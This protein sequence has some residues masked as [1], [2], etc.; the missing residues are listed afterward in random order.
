MRVL[1]LLDTPHVAGTEKHVLTLA[2][3]SVKLCGTQTGIVCLKGSPLE[4]A[5]LALGIET[6]PL[7][8]GKNI[9]SQVASLTAQGVRNADILH[10]HNGRTLL[11]A[12][13]VSRNCRPRVVYTQHFLDPGFQKHWGPIRAVYRWGHQAVNSRVAHFIAVSEEAKRRMV[14]REGVSADRITVIPNGIAPDLSRVRS[15]VDVRRELGIGE[16][17]PMAVCVSRLEQ[18]KDVGTLVRAMV[19]VR[20]ELP[21]AMCVIVGDGSQRAALESLAHQ[22]GLSEAVLFAGHLG[23]ALSV[24][25]AGDLLVLSSI[26]EP[27]GLVLLEAMALSKAVVATDAGGPREI[28]LNG[29]TGLLAP[30]RDPVALAGAMTRLLSDRTEAQA[31]GERGRCRFLERYTADRMAR[32]TLQVYRRVLDGS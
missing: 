22:Q 14:E 11:G 30:P 17:T 27:F 29:K 13:I 10:C 20:R 12:S 2:E 7:F 1:H 15:R 25:G 4:R 19:E 23:D 5:A 28:V 32:D 21:D 31:L 26:A 16:Q 6:L 9:L 8:K 24:I 18:E 3:A